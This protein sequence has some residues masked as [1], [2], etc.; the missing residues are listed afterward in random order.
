MQQIVVRVITLVLISLAVTGTMK[1]LRERSQIAEEGIVKL[2]K[3]I[4]LV[5]IMMI[6]F[7][8]IFAM[9]IYFVSQEVWVA[10]FF[11]C[12][13]FSGVFFIIAWLN[14][15]IIY[16]KQSITR[17]TFFGRRQSYS[18]YDITKI[19]EN[20]DTRIY[21]G[22]NSI[23][24]DEIAIGGKRFINFT[25]IQYANTHDG[26]EIP[27]AKRSRLDPFDGHVDS[28]GEFVFLYVLF[29]AIIIG[30]TV[31]IAV[32]SS[33]ISIDKLEHLQTTFAYYQIDEKELIIYKTPSDL[34][35]V[36]NSY[37]KYT[38]N[39]SLLLKECDGKTVFDVYAMK[40]NADEG[41][42][43]FQVMSLKDQTG[44]VFLTLENANAQS[45]SDEW[46]I[47]LFVGVVFLIWT[48]Y[49]A[50]SIYVGRN[51]RKFSKKTIR[52]FFKDGYV[53]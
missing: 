45:K 21:F 25:K 17:K 42:P 43:Y 47:Y 3:L 53:H 31:F 38:E 1:W 2:P 41:I 22:K 52:L 18:Y 26:S 40:Y 19:R 33:P 13:S 20:K 23:F 9:I 35:Y 12:V 14:G 50:C 36:I 5:G 7:F 51:P 15:E 34:T 27:K 46:M 4:L 39:T 37:I 11:F 8:G 6:I 48:M 28:Y 44:T 24:I 29:Y 49:V 10:L 32:I 16:D 30:F